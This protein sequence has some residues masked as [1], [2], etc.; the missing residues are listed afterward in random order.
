ME[1]LVQHMSTF[2]IRSKLADNIGKLAILE[3]NFGA[4]ASC[5]ASSHGFAHT[6]SQTQTQVLEPLFG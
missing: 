4:F 2:I 6:E 3:A 5:S 1:V